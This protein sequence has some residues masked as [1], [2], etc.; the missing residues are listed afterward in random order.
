MLQKR[1]LLLDTG[2][3][4]WSLRANSIPT[5][6]WMQL[7]IW[8]EYKTMKLKTNTI[9]VK[10]RICKV[11]QHYMHDV[12]SI[13]Q[14]PD[15]CIGCNHRGLSTSIIR[16]AMYLYKPKR[17]AWHSRTLRG[18]FTAY[19]VQWRSVKTCYGLCSWAVD[20]CQPSQLLGAYVSISVPF[21]CWRGQEKNHKPLWPWPN[22]QKG[23]GAA[24]PAQY[25]MHWL[26]GRPHAGC[27]DIYATFHSI[28]I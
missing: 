16:V 1:V 3:A 5:Q 10:Q 20:F 22:A 9:S 8:M 21:T 27:S 15:T 18:P 6:L 4:V 17:N 12:G 19:A 26:L 14:A 25:H 2:L 24:T 11:T 23:R 7:W 28:L 13:V